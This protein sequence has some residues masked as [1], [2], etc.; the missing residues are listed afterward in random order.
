MVIQANETPLLEEKVNSSDSE[1][2]LEQCCRIFDD[3][4]ERDLFP[5]I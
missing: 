3:Q 2:F 4:K 1:M 5:T